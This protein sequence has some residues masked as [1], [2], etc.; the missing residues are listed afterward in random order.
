MNNIELF[1]YEQEP[2]RIVLVDGEQAIQV[3]TADNEKTP[4][5]ARNRQIAA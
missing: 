2:I 4:F 3:T 5:A 1:T